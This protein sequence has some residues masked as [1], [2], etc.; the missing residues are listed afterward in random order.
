MEHDVILIGSD[1]LGQG[2]PEL[3]G[4]IL[5]NFLRLL[6]KRDGKPEYIILWNAG[7]KTAVEGS[8]WVPHLQHLE[9]QG[10]TIL[11]CQ[12]CVEFF[13]ISGQIAAGKVTGMVQIQDVL[14]TRRVLT[15]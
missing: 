9:K 1:G 15:V 2:N 13:G 6:G 14:F 7:A 5:A 12:T 10:V 11:I 8:D 4:K 3:G